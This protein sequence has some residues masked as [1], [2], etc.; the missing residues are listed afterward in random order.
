[1][2]VCEMDVALGLDDVDLSLDEVGDVGGEVMLVLVLLLSFELSFLFLFG[3][4]KIVVPLPLEREFEVDEDE[5]GDAPSAGGK[6]GPDDEVL[7][8]QSSSWD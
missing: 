6:E 8:S 7:L 4:E 5:E 1:M 2:V 3:L